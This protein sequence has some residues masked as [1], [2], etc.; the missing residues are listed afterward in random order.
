M[1]SLIHKYGIFEK[2]GW[3]A[4]MTFKTKREAEIM[5]RKQRKGSCE[6]REI[7]K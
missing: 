5:L 7:I 2:G 1:S 3:K 6:I 4:I